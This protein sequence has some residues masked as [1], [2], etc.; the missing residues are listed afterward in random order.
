MERLND[1][2]QGPLDHLEELR[3][4]IIITLAGWIILTALSYT[5]SGRLLDII[6]GPLA[7]YQ[8][9]PYFTHPVEPFMA[10]FKISALM[11]AFLNIPNMLIQ[12]WKFV[13]PA[14]ESD[15]ER[16]AFLYLSWGFPVFFA[17]GALF[18]FYVIVPLGLRFLFAFSRGEMAPL[19]SMSSY[20]N[21]ILVFIL[22]L[23]LVFNL[24]VISSGLAS[25]G[26]INSG[27]MRAG[28][29]YAILFSFILAAFITPPDVVS[30]ILVSIPLILLYEISILLCSL[31]QSLNK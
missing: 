3:F 8:E 14:L 21:F 9:K 30:Q 1:D 17:L 24:P 10:V 31:I 23:G 16:R 27:M 7:K 22:G 13:S 12:V 15:K 5:F 28:R 26:I 11:G 25:A 20:L 6:T 18:G 29:R 19:I 2:S 4:R